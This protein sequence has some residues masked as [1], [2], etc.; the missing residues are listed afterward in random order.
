MDLSRPYKAKNHSPSKEIPHPSWNPNA[1][2]RFQ[3]SPL[4]NFEILR[5]VS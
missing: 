3:K 5:N 1:D 2:F 4:I